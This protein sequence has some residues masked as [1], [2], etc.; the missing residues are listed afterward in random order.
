MNNIHKVKRAWKNY[1]ATG[2]VKVLS[3]GRWDDVEQLSTFGADYSNHSTELLKVM[4]EP[5]ALH[6][7]EQGFKKLIQAELKKRGKLGSK[8]GK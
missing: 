1:K 8:K 6:P 2:E 4:L 5:D 3:E 7:D